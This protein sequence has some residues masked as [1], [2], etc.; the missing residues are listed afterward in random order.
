[1]WSA[2]LARWRKLGEPGMAAVPITNYESPIAGN[3]AL[4]LAKRQN[5]TVA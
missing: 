5:V 3:C 1:M 4:R 2:S